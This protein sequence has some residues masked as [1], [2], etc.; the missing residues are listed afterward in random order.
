MFNTKVSKYEKPKNELLTYL[1][2]DKIPNVGDTWN[3]FSLDPGVKNFCLRIEARFKDNGFTCECGYLI[4]KN[5]TDSTN[6]IYNITTELLDSIY[7][8]YIIQCNYFIIEKQLPHCYFSNRIMQ[9]VISYLLLKIPEDHPCQIIEMSS[10]LKSS[11]LNVPK[12]LNKNATKQWHKQW[13]LERCQEDGDDFTYNALQN[14]SKKDDFADTKAMVE[15][16]L[17]YTNKIK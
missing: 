3:V 2:K 15:A 13:A 14:N 11:Q 5:L 10:R 9:H 17:I 8:R 6:N 1:R 16:F 4:K 7:D 12:G